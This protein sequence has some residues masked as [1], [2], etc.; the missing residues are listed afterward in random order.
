[1]APL[2]FAQQ[3]LWFLDQLQPNSAVYNIPQPIRLKGALQIEALQQALDEIVRRHEVLRTTYPTAEDSPVQQINPATPVALRTIDLRH[4]ADPQREAALHRELVAEAQTPFK[5]R[6]DLMLRALLV[7]LEPQENVLLLTIHHIAADAW[8][9]GVILN[10]LGTLYNCFSK[11]QPSPLPELPVQY[12]HFA[13]QRRDEADALPEQLAYWK[14][15]LAQ[16]PSLFEWP[17]DKPRPAIQSYRG[18]SHRFLVPAGTAECLQSL[19][20]NEGCTT[21]MTLLAAFQTLAFRYTGREDIITG[22]AIANRSRPEFESLAGFFVNTLP[23]RT[24]LDPGMTF[25]QLL[26]QVRRVTI[27]AY[28]HQDL[29]FDRLVEELQPERDTSYQPLI[30]TMFIQLNVPM[31]DTPGSGIA[32]MPFELDFGQSRFDLTLEMNET[33]NGLEGRLE[34][35]ADLFEQAT[36]ARMAGQFQ[37]LLESVI[38]NP[39]TPLGALGVLPESERQ[40]LLVE[41]NNTAMETPNDCL[42]A[43]FEEQ[44]HRTPGAVAIIKGKERLTYEELNQRA[45]AVAARLI[46]LGA[47]HDNLVGICMD[48]SLDL[49]SGILGILKS[50]AA[51]VALDP[52]YPKDRVDFMLSDSKAAIVLTQAKFAGRFTEGALCIEDIHPSIHP[53]AHPPTNSLAYVIYTSGSTG[54]PKGVAVEHRSAV[55]LVSWAKTVYTPEQLDGVLACTSVCFDLSV[56]ELF[57]PLCLGGKVILA[58]NAMEL[59]SL[60]AAGEAR[61][62]N[63]VPSAI[64]QLL[65]IKGIPSSIEVINLA[66]EPL[67]RQLADRIYAETNAQKVYDLYGPTEDTVYATCALRKP[68]GPATIGRPIANNKL[69]ILSPQGQPTPVGVP[70]ELYIGGEALAR[71]YLG[72]PDLTAERFVRDP[73]SPDPGARMYRTGD[74]ARYLPD[75]NVEF[76]GRMDHQVKIRGFRIELEEIEELLREH[77]TVREAVVMAREDRGGDKRLAAYV[78]ARNGQ[79]PQPNALTD[80][81]NQK[82]PDYMVPRLYTVLDAFPLTPNGKIDRQALPTPELAREADT[83]FMEPTTEIE[84]LL[85]GI[86][87]EVLELECVGVND[88]FFKLGGHSLKITQVISRVREALEIEL[89]MRTMFEAPTIASLALRIEDLLIQ[90]LNALSEE[91]AQKL[92]ERLE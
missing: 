32:W 36:I 89:P 57:V 88:N 17:T 26:Q 52:T 1:L 55:N 67:T 15:Q 39:D 10:E 38:K 77:P 41:W 48:R 63:T 65:D 19:A 6:E 46:E 22:S 29:P 91:E 81:L 90:E 24:R 5:L 58:E 85:A 82:L 3:R 13:Q 87:C 79:P 86:W 9:L 44:V 31:P 92:N 60:P 64:T 11:G 16:A 50:G 54:R 76:L 69:Y 33:R 12:R 75:G 83:P 59:P 51:Y 70:G 47:G 40:R 71:G 42:H 23:L 80:W 49:V 62:L 68:G 37:T 43:L 74:L 18:G 4:L 20:R 61:L 45:G 21:F 28:Q 8:S 7:Q 14:T 2:S 53:S 27:D 35:A 84:R 25:R 73:F 66:G 34:Y 56:F 72:R 30:Q 78:T